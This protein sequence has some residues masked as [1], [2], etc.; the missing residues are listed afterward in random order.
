MHHSYWA[1]ARAHALQQEKSHKEL[2]Y[3]DEE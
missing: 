1:C 2:T 3:S